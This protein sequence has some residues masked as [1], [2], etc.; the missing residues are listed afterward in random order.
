[1]SG[2]ASKDIDRVDDVVRLVVEE[3]LTNAKKHAD[4]RMVLV[5]LRYEPPKL[6]LVIQDDGKGAP[7]A[8]LRTFEDSYLHFGL[9]TSVSW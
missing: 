4:A 1:M 2:S 8:L 5:S 9:A 6:D 3:V 7:G